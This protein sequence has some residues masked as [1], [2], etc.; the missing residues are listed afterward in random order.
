MSSIT[1]EK[2]EHRQRRHRRIRARVHGSEKRP[3]LS[4]FRS[5]RYISAQ[6]IDDEEG[7]TILGLSTKDLKA[8]GT[9]SEQARLL[10]GK[11]AEEAKQ[12]SIVKVVFD[13]G[14]YL[15]TGNVKALAD[16]AREG[17]LQF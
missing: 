6:L 14:G 8:K 5:N 12:K 17:G 2:G 15:Y 4:V 9:L 3:R 1:K 7:K 16:G 10:G 11:I 13:R